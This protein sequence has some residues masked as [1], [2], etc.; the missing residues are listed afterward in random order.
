MGAAGADG[1]SDVIVQPTN[2][3]VVD[4]FGVLFHVNATRG[5]L[6]F[7]DDGVDQTHFFERLIPVLDAFL[8]PASITNRRGVFNEEPNRFLGRAQLELGVA[9]L[10]PPAVDVTNTRFLV[11]ILAEV[12]E[13]GGE[14]PDALI[15]DTRR[16]SAAG[17]GDF[18]DRIVEALKVA[19][20]S[21]DLECKFNIFGKDFGFV[22]RHDS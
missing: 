4:I 21:Y 7:D 8:Y 13:G 2:E 22:D 1:R 18:A 5:V 9:F 15:G 14:V 3:V 12:G 19:G 6:I 16:K 17:S 20:P 11:V 10:K